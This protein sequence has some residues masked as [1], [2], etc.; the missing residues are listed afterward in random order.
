[1]LGAIIGD[2][3]GSAYEWNNVKHKEFELFTDTTIFTDDTVM[4]IA[5]IDAIINDIPFN[6]SYKKWFR[7]YPNEDYGGNFYYWGNSDSLEPY[8]SWGNGSA[9]RVSPV[10][11]YYDTLDEV[12]LKSKESAEA[13]HN[14]AEGIKGAQATAS[15]IYLA[16][17]KKN[18]LE[19]K[20]FIENTFG[21]DLNEKLD[22]IRE[23]YE[24]DESCQGTVPQ[25]II[26]FLESNDF[27]D[28]IRNAISIGGD[29]DTLA[30]IT[31][32]IA[33]AYYREI[34]SSILSKV[35]SILPQEMKLLVNE[36][37]EKNVLN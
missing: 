37:Y 27:E 4:T 21:Y 33:E 24:F 1:M 15:A 26:A 7:K 25:A 31:G 11:I 36:L 13:T 8:N 20:E 2:I 12:L 18:K 30:C 16:K 23:W 22:S 32:G 17:N 35:S 9:M 6:K 29:S 3:I 10:G 14:H 19:I 28:A 5:T 34:P